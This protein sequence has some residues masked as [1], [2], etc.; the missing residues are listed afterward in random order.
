MFYHSIYSLSSR[1]SSLLVTMTKVYYMSKV[2]SSLKKHKNVK[3][4][5]VERLAKLNLHDSYY[6]KQW[7][8]KCF[9]ST[10]TGFNLGSASYHFTI[11][12][13]IAEGTD[14]NQRIGRC[15]RMLRL[16]MWIRVT[17]LKLPLGAA[18]LEDMARIVLLYDEQ[19]AGA[20]P[21]VNDVFF[22][23]NSL[24]P[25]NRNNC[26][27]FEIIKDRLFAISNTNGGPQCYSVQWDI[28]LDHTVKFNA[29]SGTGGS[30]IS[31]GALVLGVGPAT[32]S[33]VAQLQGLVQVAY[34]LE[35]SDW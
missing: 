14:Y 24:A 13:E 33:T 3:E 8:G 20:P 10:P 26:A 29:T 23:G 2:K 19:P 32:N 34:R 27:R 15:I 16:R 11:I 30:D 18:Y 17:G 1:S 6:P 12:N 4:Y 5:T 25:F 9:D 22:G 7:D 35:Y 28:S 21:T 31:S